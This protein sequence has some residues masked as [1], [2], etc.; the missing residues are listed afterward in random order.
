MIQTKDLPPGLDLRVSDG[1]EG[2]PAFDRNKLP[3]EE[4]G[5][6]RVATAALACGPI[7]AD[8]DD[9][10]AFALRPGSQPAPR[11][12]QVIKGQFPP[13]PSSLLPPKANDA[14]QALKVLRFM[15]EGVVPLAPELSVTF[16]QP[17]V[18]VTSQSDAAQPQNV[19]IELT[20]TPKGNWRWIGTR[21]VL[22]DPV[23]RFPQATTYRVQ[24][25]AGTKSANGGVLKE[26]VKF[27]FETP[28]PTLKSSY[29]SPYQPQ[30]LDVPMFALFDQ[31]IDR[32]KVIDKISVR[33]TGSSRSS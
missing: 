25:P 2:P 30:R 19:P 12:G 24:I 20:P 28:A 22:F 7:T 32:D 3:R 23:T 14:G 29:P 6:R 16:S 26:A 15:P 13:P 31:K 21:T 17:M 10:K 5:R 18:A 33:A 9:Q 8:A 1:R 11:T 27:T 4:A